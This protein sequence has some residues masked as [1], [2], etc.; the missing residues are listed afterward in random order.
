M[1]GGSESPEGAALLEAVRRGDPAAVQ[2]CLRQVAQQ[3]A[4]DGKTGRAPLHVAA[5]AGHADVLRVLVEADSSPVDPRDR[6]GN[7]PLLTAVF[8]GHE[9]CVKVLLDSGADPNIFNRNETTPLWRAIQ[10]DHWSICQLLIDRGARISRLYEN[11]WV[12]L[13]HRLVTAGPVQKGHWSI[14][15]L[16][17]DRGARIGRLYENGWVMLAHRLVTAG[18]QERLPALF[19]H[20]DTG[21]AG[22]K[23]GLLTA[24][25]CGRQQDVET[26]LGQG[27][28]VNWQASDGCTALHLAAQYNQLACLQV[29]LQ[30]GADANRTTG[31]EQL[32]Q[33][34]ANA[35]RT[36]AGGQLQGGADAYRTTA[37]GQLP[38][39]LATEAG[40][41]RCVELLCP[42]TSKDAVNKC[43]ES[44]FH[45]AVAG[46]HAGCI[47][48]LAEAGFNPNTLPVDGRGKRGNS[49]L[50]GAVIRKD[51]DCIE[52]LLKSGADPNLD[53]PSVLCEAIKQ[54]DLELMRLLIQHGADVNYW[55]TPHKSVVQSTLLFILQQPNQV[56]G[57][58]DPQFSRWS[59]QDML[60]LLLDTGLRPDGCFRCDCN[61]ST[62]I[63][64]Q[65]KPGKRRMYF[66]EHARVLRV[67]IAPVVRLLL[68]YCREVTLC[69]RLTLVLED[70][71]EWD[72]II[73]MIGR[74][75]SLPHLC[76]LSVRRAVGSRRLAR[77][78]WA[79]S[80]P[81]PQKVQDF[82]QFKSRIRGIG[83]SRAEQPM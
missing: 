32:L 16:L 27:V 3:Q 58:A 9:E 19:P 45:S 11:G 50:H 55:Y 35:N 70:M 26:L 68:E 8:K 53:H 64:P 41:D 34:G 40:H 36:T 2:E 65:H 56:R 81:V 28:D 47:K 33:G 80:L 69:T 29:L 39:H 38:L 60:K 21:Q 52:E 20:V 17:I 43:P 37:G 75:R 78:N 4:V 22:D 67:K 57:L 25:Q 18:H 10:K 61:E 42:A 73:T 46:R 83:L 13:A 6:E 7:T 31:G 48:L 14:C 62:A 49:A 24:A 44:P 63:I 82:I 77:E 1:Q 15:Q 71:C 12:M 79:D 5:A 51:K 59:R 66:C 74:M 76:R 54:R 30:G 72:R 23:H